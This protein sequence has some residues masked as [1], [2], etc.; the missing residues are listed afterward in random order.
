[1]P[2]NTDILGML[3]ILLLFVKKQNL[4]QLHKIAHLINNIERI[5]QVAL[6]PQVLSAF[7]SL[8]NL[9]PLL[10]SLSG[11]NDFE[12]YENENRNAIF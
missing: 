1:M 3:F 5:S 6:N 12:D 4:S 2:K 8:E 11:D 10:S 9:S 7:S